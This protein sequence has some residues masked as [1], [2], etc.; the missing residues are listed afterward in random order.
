M[1]CVRAAERL[2]IAPPP[3]ERGPDLQLY[4]IFT[5]LPATNLALQAANQLAL[6]LNARVTLLVAQVV[7][8]PLPQECPPVSI[9]F[10]EQVLSRL[11]G[12]KEVETAVHVYLCRDRNETIRQALGPD[13]IVVIGGRKRWWRNGEKTLARLLRRDGHRVIVFDINRFHLAE[14]LFKNVGSTR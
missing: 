10:T 1:T 3:H 2:S 4:V 5:D 6:D 11:L 12:D 13:S 8:Y 9:E 14:A 7:P